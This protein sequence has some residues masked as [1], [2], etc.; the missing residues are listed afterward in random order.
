MTKSPKELYHEGIIE[1]CNKGFT[2]KEMK[3]ILHIRED[4]IIEVLEEETK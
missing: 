4:Y 1:M 3:E 2:V